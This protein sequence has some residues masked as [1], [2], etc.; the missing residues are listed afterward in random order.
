M[1]ARGPA[2]WKVQLAERAGALQLSGTCPVHNGEVVVNLQPMPWLE[3]EI[4]P[5]PTGVAQRRAWQDKV[6]AQRRSASG[7]THRLANTVTTVLWCHRDGVG[8]EVTVS[9]TD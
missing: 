8:A 4:D 7:I 5:E 6:E 2:T 3:P 1:T 9:L